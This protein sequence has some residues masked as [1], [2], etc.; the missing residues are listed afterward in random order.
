MSNA[1]VAAEID[2]RQLAT[3]AGIGSHGRAPARRIVVVDGP[4]HIAR[5]RVLPSWRERDQKIDRDVFPL[6]Q[7][8]H[9]DDIVGALGVTDQNQRTALAG[10]MIFDNVR[11]CRLPSQ[12]PDG[13][14]FDPFT[15]EFC[16]QRVEPG[17][18]YAKPAAQEIDSG[19]RL[20][21]GVPYERS[22]NAEDAK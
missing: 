8:S 13:L 1:E 7:A 4:Y 11:N 5:D 20:S 14:S 21:R 10:G 6:E 15:P 16:G 18:E 12:M 17:R 2:V 22:C 9:I 19:V 3:I